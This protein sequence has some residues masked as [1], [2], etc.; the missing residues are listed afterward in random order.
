MEQNRDGGD[1]WL[2]WTE[3]L[4]RNHHWISSLRHFTSSTF[5]CSYSRYLFMS[6]SIYM[7]YSFYLNTEHGWWSSQVQLLPSSARLDTKGDP[8]GLKLLLMIWESLKSI[9]LP[10]STQSPTWKTRASLSQYMCLSYID[11]ITDQPM[12]RKVS[13]LF[14]LPTASESTPQGR[15]S[16][17]VTVQDHSMLHGVN[18]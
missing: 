2:R 11:A 7:F 6:L 13:S 10:N 16:Y 15:S 12:H 8:N 5:F 14:P 9:Y 4:F 17:R 18:I 3:T 1:G